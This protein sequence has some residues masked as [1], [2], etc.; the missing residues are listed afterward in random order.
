MK[1]SKG[2]QDIW[3]T[4]EGTMTTTPTVT[5]QKHL[6]FNIVRLLKRTRDKRLG[7]RQGRMSLTVEDILK[8]FFNENY[9]TTRLY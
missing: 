6:L 1:V 3:E 5:R 2:I 9:T 8:F 4:L 7:K